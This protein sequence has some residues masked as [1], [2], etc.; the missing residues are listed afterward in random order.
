MTTS[1]A[2]VLAFALFLALLAMI[3]A[4]FRL[5]RSGAMTSA[6]AAAVGGVTGG[7]SLLMGLVLA[8]SFSNAAE[9]LAYHRSLAVMEAN[10]I[11][12]GWARIDLLA[13]PDQAPLRDLF[14][15]YLDARIRAHEALPRVEEYD[16]LLVEGTAL[17]Q[18]IWERMIAA[19]RVSPELGTLVIPPINAMEDA[20]INRKVAVHTH[21]TE[22]TI[23]FMLGLVLLGALLIG[24]SGAE[25]NGR[26]WPYRLIFAAM[27]ATAVIVIFDMEFP[28]T[29]FAGT[30]AADELL[31]ELRRSMG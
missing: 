10:A 3:E 31:V 1:L 30:R 12:T 26:L 27:T 8:F 14:R 25:R 21:V 29:G 15:R 23:A 6:V 18:G 19:V 2:I 13:E 16:A 5:T 20:A 22:M 24:T 9:R 7:V 11:A 17:R 4:G 28:Q